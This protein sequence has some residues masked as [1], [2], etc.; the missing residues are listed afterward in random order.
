MSMKNR[1]QHVSEWIPTELLSLKERMYRPEWN[2]GD[3]MPADWFGFTEWYIHYCYI[4]G[5]DSYKL[6]WTPLPWP[7]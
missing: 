7:S 1:T 3:W 5:I 4:N 6:G 2:N